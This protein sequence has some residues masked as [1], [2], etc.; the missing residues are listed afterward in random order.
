MP[1]KR[2]KII[3][4][5]KCSKD[6]GWYRSNYCDECVSQGWHRVRFKDA[7]PI[8]MRTI[9]DMVNAQSNKNS[10]NRFN[11]IRLHARNKIK[12]LKA[13]SVCVNCKYDKH[14]EVCHI[15]PI[16]AFTSD[17]LVSIVNADDNL[18]LLCP[19]CHWEH[20]NNLLKL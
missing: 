12:Q 17:T 7:K 13:P 18:I 1:R 19:N 11:A 4:C 8:S 20:D 9:E 16:N 5:K 14:V 3:L 15:K 2:T 6:T 10:S